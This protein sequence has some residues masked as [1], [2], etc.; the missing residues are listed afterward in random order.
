M[1]YKNLPIVLAV[2]CMALASAVVQ[3]AEPA[4]WLRNPAISPD[5]GNVVFSHRGDL[6]SVPV[7]G[8]LAT[9]L[10]VHAAHVGI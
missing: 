2:L 5:G 1:Q 6:W 3:A 8:G 10:T 4:L 7:E 9:Q